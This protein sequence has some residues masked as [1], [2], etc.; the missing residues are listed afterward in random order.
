MKIVWSPT[1]IADLESI[2]IYIA[3]DSPA[4]AA[5]IALHIKESVQQLSRFPLSGREGRVSGTRELVIS[6]T[7][8]L[9]AYTCN[10]KEVRIASV[11]HGKRR[12]PEMF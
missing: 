11:L 7:P 6:G 10:D 8:Y 5:K 2:R 3:E 4:S 9:A 12:W 1:A